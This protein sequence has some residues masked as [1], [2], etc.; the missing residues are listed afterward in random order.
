MAALTRDEGELVESRLRDGSRVWMYLGDAVGRTVYWCADHDPKITWVCRRVL[1]PGDTCVDVGANIGAVALQAARL[2]GAR[3]A[4]HAIEPQPDL[5]ALLRRSAEANGYGQLRVH[6]L[7]LSDRDGE[8]PLYLPV[9]ANR[10]AA[11][12]DETYR[13]GRIEIRVPVRHAGRFL[14][15][16][17]GSGVRLLKV[18]VENHEE[19]VFSGAG[20]WL[21][22]HPP[23]V[24]LFESY[25]DRARPF[26]SRAAVRLLSERGY[27]IYRVPKALVR[28]R[29][30]PIPRGSEPR[31]PGWDFVGV[32]ERASETRPRLDL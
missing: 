28:M 11:S 22:R 23:D 31:G 1:R 13:P 18:D 26:W 30:E 19:P 32:H 17:A 14:E 4:V 20:E 2:V 5:A 27:A 8:L 24:I 6:P 29:L 9:P 16:V 7:G 3:G 21:T 25:F 10:G 12:M 15:E